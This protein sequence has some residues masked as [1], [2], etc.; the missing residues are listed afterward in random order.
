MQIVNKVVLNIKNVSITKDVCLSLT[1]SNVSNSIENKI[2][3]PNNELK[4]GFQFLNESQTMV[5]E[6]GIL[7]NLNAVTKSDCLSVMDSIEKEG[8]EHVIESLVDKTIWSY[9]DY[10]INHIHSCSDK[11][12]NECFNISKSPEGKFI[13]ELLRVNVFYW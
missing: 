2:L 10:I 13:I 8:S 12:C 7:N 6:S 4:K 5:L 1:S 9:K 11:M 3:Y